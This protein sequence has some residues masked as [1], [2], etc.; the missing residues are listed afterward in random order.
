MG[1]LHNNK[2]KNKNKNKYHICVQRCM[3]VCQL[4]SYGTESGDVTKIAMVQK[5][6]LYTGGWV[7][8]TSS[9]VHH[10]SRASSAAFMWYVCVCLC[11]FFK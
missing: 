11:V 3:C 9:A 1:V 8:D 7:Y 2:D 6:S 5:H 10:A 4:I